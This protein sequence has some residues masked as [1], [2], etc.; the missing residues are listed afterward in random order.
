FRNKI[1]PAD[2]RKAIE[3]FKQAIA[4][5]PSS[6]Q[7][8]AMVAQAYSQLGMQGQM[9]PHTAFEIAHQYVDKALELDD[10]IAEGHIAKAMPYLFYEWKWQQ[11][12]EALQKA[13]QLNPGAAAAYDLMGFYYIAMGQKD[14]AVKILEE[15]EQEDPLSP[16]IIRSL[17]QMYIFAERFDDAIEQAEKLLDIN[18]QMRSS[19]E[20]KAWSIGMKGD[21]PA[22]VQ[23]FEEVHQLTNHPLKGL[24]GLGYAYAKTG[25]TNKAMDCI[26][27]LELRQQQEPESVVDGDLAAVWL[28]IGDLDK[29]FYYLNECIDKR[30][31]PVACF[32][33]YPPYRSVK[34]DPRFEELKKR[35]GI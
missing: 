11:A 5:E 24:M 8:Y 31:G 34:E 23:L 27:K 3:C 2:T 33:E 1:T 6:A 21:W 10:T 26:H 17:G 4:L 9:I 35:M 14:Q 13:L 30:L 28:G 15:A 22:A 16:M 20:L 12:H 18:P 19:L 25:M 29:T 7:A 32:I